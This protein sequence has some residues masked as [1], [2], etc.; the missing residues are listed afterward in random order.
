MLPIVICCFTNIVFA[1]VPVFPGAEGFGAVTVAGRGGT[2]YRVNTL[3]DN[4]SSPTLNGDGTYSGSL[5]A[6]V[7]ASGART[8]VF[9]VGGVIN[10]TSTLSI[11]NPYITIA[12]QTAPNPGIH[13]KGY[14]IHINTH[15]VLIQHIF[16][17]YTATETNDAIDVHRSPVPYNIVIDHVSASW[18]RDECLSFAPGGDNVIDNNVTYSNNLIAESQYGTLISDGTKKLSAIKNLW[19]SNVERQ[20]RIKGNV[21]TAVVNNVSYN[22]GNSYSTVVGDITGASYLSA[23]GNVYID[24]PNTTS[25][26]YGISTYSSTSPGTQVYVSDNLATNAVT[27]TQTSTY[28]VGTPPVSITGISILG[29]AQVESYVLSNAGARPAERDGII[30]NGTGNDLDERLVNEVVTGGGS[31][32]SSPPPGDI[33][34]YTQTSR[35]FSL[36]ANPNEDDD[37]DGYTNLEEVLHQA[38][39]VVESGEITYPAPVLDSA[40]YVDGNYVLNWSIPGTS[41]PSGGYDMV[42]DSVDTNSTWQTTG[43]NQII[44]GLDTTVSHSFQVEAR[45]IQASPSQ[46]PRSN[47]LTVGAVITYTVTY[48]ANGGTGTAP[49]ENDK[50]E[51]ATFIT[52]INSFTSPPGYQFIEW[53][54]AANGTGTGYTAGETVTMPGNDVT[55]YAI[56]QIAYP[57][58]VLDTVEYND[59]YFLIWSLPE[60]PTG[61]PAG[62]YDIIIDGI[63]TNTT[64][65]T[66]GTSQ[67]ITGLSTSISHTFQVEARWTQADPAEFPRSNELT[68]GLVED[69]PAPILNSVELDGSNYILRWSL[70]GNPTGT[71]AGGYD[72]VIDSV[73]TNDTW[74]TTGTSQTITGLDTTVSHTFQVEA[75]WIQANPS[76]FPRSNE[77]TVP[78]TLKSVSMGG[79]IENQIDLPVFAVYPN[80]FSE[81]VNVLNAD[82]LSRVIITNIE[83]R[84]VKDIVFPASIIPLVDLTSGI[85]F[86]TLIPKSGGKVKSIRIVK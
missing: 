34:S 38:A 56:W 46:F 17:R 4:A 20:P 67:T 84:R 79:G 70:P 37:S 72:M 53:N 73:D 25:P 68:I 60:N 13:T 82:K 58:P 55:L 21:T 31:L 44:T 74:E 41:T 14:G 1:Q 8:I 57:A 86:M 28:L 10:L 9:E 18:G 7:S 29:S 19:I 49:T 76:E 32:K 2:V 36:P 35:S 22:I 11:S 27:S 26:S 3:D 5:R 80:P 54:T 69:Y 83:G 71:P 47:E 59:G 6:A 77:L 43:T 12:G 66:T 33:P 39:A 61:V 64:W 62:G 42:I 52:A 81:Y 85:Y 48:D 50:A 40:K 63:D 78:N 30:D 15:D 23:V 16:V 45:W 24:G 51:G 75:R 65:E